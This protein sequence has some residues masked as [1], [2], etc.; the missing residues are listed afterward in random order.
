MRSSHAILRLGTTHVEAESTMTKPSFR[1]ILVAFLVLQLAACT[2]A[3]TVNSGRPT[4]EV[5]A[6]VERVVEDRDTFPGRFDAVEAVE[7]RPRV[8]GYVDSVHF[9]DGDAVKKG[10]LLFR[11]DPRPYAAA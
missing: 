9:K 11:I 3:P 10:D 5:A 2:K 8:S 6:P 7:V 4:V 1:P